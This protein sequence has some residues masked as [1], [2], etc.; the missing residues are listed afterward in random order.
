MHADIDV[1]GQSLPGS[2]QPT[3]P[4]WPA[5]PPSTP[6]AL[7]HIGDKCGRNSHCGTRKPNNAWGYSQVTVCRNPPAARLF[8]CR[9]NSR[10]TPSTPLA[11]VSR[12]PPW[13]RPAAHLR[14]SS[15]MA[16]WWLLL[17]VAPG[18]L[19]SKVLPCSGWKPCWSQHVASILHPEFTGLHPNQTAAPVSSISG[20]C[21][22]PPS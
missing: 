1:N 20:P 18:A 11:M 15:T 4:H 16:L 14:W 13:R 6:G 12:R 3:W 22:K 8:P 17:D 9:H 10:R 21:L 2:R 5:L 19:Q 7:A